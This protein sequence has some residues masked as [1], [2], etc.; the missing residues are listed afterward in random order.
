MR[1]TLVGSAAISRFASSGVQVIITPNRKGRKNNAASSLSTP[2]D[3]TP[4]SDPIVNANIEV[5][6]SA[7]S[8][9]ESPVTQPES[10]VAPASEA[11]AETVVQ[12]VIVIAG[13]TYG[14]S[15]L[16][17]M[18]KSRVLALLETCDE[19]IDAANA[20]AYATI[21]AATGSVQNAERAIQSWKDDLAKHTAV[22]DTA[23]ASL[24]SKNTLVFQVAKQ[25]GLTQENREPVKVEVPKAEGKKRRTSGTKAPKRTDMDELTLR[26]FQSVDEAVD[27]ISVNDVRARLKAQGVDGSAARSLWCMR[28]CARSESNPSGRAKNAILVGHLNSEKKMTIFSLNDAGRAAHQRMFP[29]MWIADAASRSDADQEP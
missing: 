22:L 7:D 6:M 5:P 23:K 10:E 11:P 17:S 27:G 3:A 21:E 9:V 13:E 1:H 12:E 8:I 20:S 4:V 18:R 29:D 15:D 28:L 14:M 2:S 25:L 16:L 19:E 26:C 24:R